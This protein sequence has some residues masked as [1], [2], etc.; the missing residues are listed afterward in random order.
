MRSFLESQANCTSAKVRVIVNISESFVRRSV[1]ECCRGR[2][3][4]ACFL[5]VV[6]LVLS[7]LHSELF[8]Y[9]LPVL[10]HLRKSFACAGFELEASRE[11]DYASHGV[12]AGLYWTLQKGVKFWNL[13]VYCK[14]WA[15]CCQSVPLPPPFTLG[16]RVRN[17]CHVTW[18]AN[19][20]VIKAT[21]FKVFAIALC[22]FWCFLYSFITFH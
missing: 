5:F 6:F 20:N 22:D 1:P 8:S 3:R 4:S 11:N 10:A 16:L 15:Q 2:S 17:V 7:L 18:H 14:P 21:T 13:H 9:L 19:I 12:L